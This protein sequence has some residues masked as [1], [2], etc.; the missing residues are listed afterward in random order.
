M[1]AG[2]QQPG[3]ESAAHRQEH[4]DVVGDGR[5]LTLGQTG[6]ATQPELLLQLLEQ[7]RF[8]SCPNLTAPQPAALCVQP[9]REAVAAR[10]HANGTSVSSAR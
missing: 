2:V 7:V 6:S 5:S 10:M 3:D 1:Q 9:A 4:V 8:S